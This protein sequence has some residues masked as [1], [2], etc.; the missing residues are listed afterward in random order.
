[1]C[2][3]KPVVCGAVS[4]NCSLFQDSYVWCADLDL[5]FFPVVS[6]SHILYVCSLTG[7]F[8]FLSLDDYLCIYLSVYYFIYLAMYVCMYV[9]SWSKVY[10]HLYI[11]SSTDF[12]S[13]HVSVMEW[14]EQILL[15][16]KKP[17]WSSDLIWICYRSS[18]NVTKSAGSTTYI[19]P[20]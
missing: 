16:H 17:L 8:M 11:F 4:G 1:M 5:L 15:C 9:Q 14:V 12:Y 7:L 18:E 20:F 10:I 6:L 2:A 13:W 19:Q 3:L